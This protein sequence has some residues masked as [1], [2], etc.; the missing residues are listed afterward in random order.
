LLAKSA[1]LRQAADGILQ[2]LSVFNKLF[3]NVSWETVS[4][5]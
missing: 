2:A 1:H 3:E 5:Q 4:E